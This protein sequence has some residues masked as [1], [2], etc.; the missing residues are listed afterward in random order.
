MW[1]I[2][3][4]K[5]NALFRFVRDGKAGYIDAAGKV[6]IQPTLPA[7]GTWGGEFHEGLLQ[8]GEDKEQRYIDTFGKTVLRPDVSYSL[9]FSQGLAAAA[10]WREV[11]GVSDRKYGF[12]DRSGRF[13]I[14]D[15][16]MFVESFSDGLARVSVSGEVGSTG[17]IDTKGAVVIPTNLSYGSNFHQGRAAVIISGPCRITNGG[18]CARAT[19]R[20]TQSSANYDCKWAFIDKSGK[21]ISDGRFDD[22]QDFS[23]GLAA[24][25]LDNKWGFVDLSGKIV[26]PPT[27]ERVDSFSEGLAAVGRKGEKTGFI[28]RTG[29]FVIRPQFDYAES[30][31]NGRALVTRYGKDYQA[32]GSRFIGKDGKAAFSGEFT[33][34]TSFHRGLAHVK[35]GDN[36][37]A[38]IDPA[39]KRVFTYEEK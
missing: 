2:R 20:P 36:R 3:D 27:F 8:I 30:F 15:Q 5:A 33:V 19:F 25:F 24:V 10:V 14:P 7:T 29:A 4:P 9:D 38:W 37:F 17:Y 23:E 32:L 28:D 34:A 11:N 21:P 22:A 31:S 39:G 6:V 12:I 26:I 35:I 16:Y 1:G 18:S 13:A